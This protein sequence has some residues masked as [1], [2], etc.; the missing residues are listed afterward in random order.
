MSHMHCPNLRF[1]C[2]ICR[3]ISLAWRILI[4]FAFL[5]ILVLII[6]D[7]SAIWNSWVQM[8][9]G[10]CIGEVVT[11]DDW[12]KSLPSVFLSLIGAPI[13]AYI[14]HV[15]GVYYS[16][17]N[18]A[19]R[20]WKLHNP[21]TCTVIISCTPRPVLRY[22]DGKIVEANIAKRLFGIEPSTAAE[23]KDQRPVY[24]Q[25]RFDTGEGQVK[26]LAFLIS[27]LRDAYGDD[28]DWGNLYLS[29]DAV[30]HAVEVGGARDLILLGGPATNRHTKAVLELI[31][32][33]LEI[34]PFNGNGL[35]VIIKK[36]SL[37]A[38]YGVERVYEKAD[39]GSKIG[40]IFIRR[41]YSVIIRLTNDAAHSQTKTYIFA[42]CTTYGTALAA[43]FFCKHAASH[44]EIQS[45]GERDF[46][47]IVGTDLMP[48]GIPLQSM[49]LLNVYPLD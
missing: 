1:C 20:L 26:A 34:N 48:G 31:K 2:L 5:N 42:G 16:T 36:N 43:H 9:C 19:R 8:V 10:L 37:T 39:T 4:C 7:V 46:V 24:E 11:V 13:L 21:K 3:N 49:K 22:D 25:C 47:A 18:P 44:P 38:N 28:I 35:G 15:A 30:S 41:D 32:D 12:Q 27:S 17:R 45:M 29:G 14:W 40:K 23:I 33:K 6:F